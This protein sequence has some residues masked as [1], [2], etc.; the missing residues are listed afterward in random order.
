MLSEACS[1]E[2]TGKDIVYLARAQMAASGT[3]AA[4][5]TLRKALGVDSGYGHAYA[6]LALSRGVD[7]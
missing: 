3:A 2:P 1:L 5:G 6:R 4:E 7:L